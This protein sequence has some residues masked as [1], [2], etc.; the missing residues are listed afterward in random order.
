MEAGGAEPVALFFALGIRCVW[1]RSERGQSG[2]RTNPQHYTGRL[3]HCTTRET[4]R[5]WSPEW[6]LQ[7][8]VKGDFQGCSEGRFSGF[9]IRTAEQPSLY[10]MPGIVSVSAALP[11]RKQQREADTSPPISA[12]TSGQGPE[13]LVFLFTLLCLNTSGSDSIFSAEGLL[14]SLGLPFTSPV[15][16]NPLLR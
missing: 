11:S 15:P 9:A 6:Q 13:M 5:L 8:A 16:P 10:H 3:R 2:N 7:R 12:G 14:G 4:S 1:S